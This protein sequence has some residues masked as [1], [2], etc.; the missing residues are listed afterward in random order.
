MYEKQSELTREQEE[1]ENNNSALF[2]ATMVLRAYIDEE[3]NVKYI[4]SSWDSILEKE[5]EN[6]ELVSK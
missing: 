4:D 6:A 2:G 1:M 3:G 5:K